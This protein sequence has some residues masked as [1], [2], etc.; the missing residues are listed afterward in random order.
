MVKGPQ[1]SRGDDPTPV[2]L[3]NDDTSQRAAGNKRIVGGPFVSECGDDID[4]IQPYKGHLFSGLEARR[5]DDFCQ[6][7]SEDDVVL[8]RLPERRDVQ[9]GMGILTFMISRRAERR[10]FS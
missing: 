7:R 3:I 6:C 10:G 5:A 2:R 9:Q 1:Q 4:V 8:L